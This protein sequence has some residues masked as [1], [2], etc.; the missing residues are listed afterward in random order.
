MQMSV[1]HR[2]IKP[3]PDAR[4]VGPADSDFGIAR[5]LHLEYLSDDARCHSANRSQ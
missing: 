3:E 4:P 5:M 1:V 2:D